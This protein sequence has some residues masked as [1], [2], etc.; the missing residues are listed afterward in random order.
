MATPPT[1]GIFTGMAVA[2]L[3][4][5]LAQAQAALIALES[6]GQ[7]A[8]VSYDQGGGNRSVT[9]TRAESGRLRQLIA[10]LQAALG[11]RSRRA[12]AVSF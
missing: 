3:Q 4:A 9:Y 5:Y 6:G 12:I 2:A 1:T 7:V 10:D 11:I 8:T